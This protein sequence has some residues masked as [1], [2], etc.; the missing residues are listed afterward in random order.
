MQHPERGAVLDAII[1]V[2]T[3]SVKTISLRADP[4][5]SVSAEIGLIVRQG[6]QHLAAAVLRTA[7][8]VIEIA[9]GVERPAAIR[10]Q[11]CH[12]QILLGG[13]GWEAS[14]RQAMGAGRLYGLVP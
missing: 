4:S 12:G 2:A 5:S 9:V 3:R 7:G 1:S 13:A 14:S 11:A 6:S 8:A 10:L